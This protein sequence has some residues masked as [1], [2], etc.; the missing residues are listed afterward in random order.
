MWE[1]PTALIRF[2]LR[3]QRSRIAGSTGFEPVECR[4]QKPMPYRL[5]MA[6]FK[7]LQTGIEPVRLLYRKILSLLRFPFSPL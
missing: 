7:M 4:H 1:K 6:Q 5:A 2:H 3:K